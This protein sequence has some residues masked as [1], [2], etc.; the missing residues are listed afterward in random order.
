[1]Y[2]RQLARPELNHFAKMRPL[3][4]LMAQE[5]ALP[6]ALSEPESTPRS[7]SNRSART[8]GPIKLESA[9]QPRGIDHAMVDCLTAVVRTGSGMASRRRGPI[10]DAR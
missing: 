6:H 8:R 3:N 7:D 10:E 4:R 5:W 9:A 1:M 2:I